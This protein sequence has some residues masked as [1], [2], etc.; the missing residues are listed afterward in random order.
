MSFHSHFLNLPK[1]M[2]LPDIIRL[3]S[4]DESIREVEFLLRSHRMR[5]IRVDICSQP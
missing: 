4:V 1:A 2:R 3:E 5:S